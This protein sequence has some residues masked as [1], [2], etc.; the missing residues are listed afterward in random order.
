MSAFEVAHGKIEP[1]LESAHVA[2]RQM[3]TGIMVQDDIDRLEGQA[4][5]NVAHAGD[6][7]GIGQ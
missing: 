1:D 3:L 4:R 7:P 2:D 6:I 5:V